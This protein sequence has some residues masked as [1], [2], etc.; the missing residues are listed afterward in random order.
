MSGEAQVV[1]LR[2][3]GDDPASLVAVPLRVLPLP[4]LDRVGVVLVSHS[5]AVA[6][7]VAGLAVALLG[8]GDPGPVATAGGDLDGRVG[9]SAGLVAAAAQ[10]A[11]QGMGVA[12]VADLD[13]AVDTVQVLL[14]NA[15]AHGLPF[16]VRLADAPFLEGAIAAVATAAAGG[17][18]AAV[19]E[20]AEDGYRVRKL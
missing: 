9:T 1:A 2:V 11:D 13:G 6:E 14:A 18:L 17:D 19:V 15:E 20:A 5:R 16:P 4:G 7:A 3:A 12:V 8:T 10:E